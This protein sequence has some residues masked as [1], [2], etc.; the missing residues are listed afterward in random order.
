MSNKLLPYHIPTEIT[1]HHDALGVFHSLDGVPG[2]ISG[3]S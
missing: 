1:P 3:D 2:V